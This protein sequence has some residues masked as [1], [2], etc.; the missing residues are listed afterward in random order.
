[1]ETRGFD[2]LHAA[3]FTESRTRGRRW[4]REVGNPGRDDKARAVTDLQFRESDGAEEL[5][6]RLADVEVSHHSPLVIPSEAEG[7][8]VGLARTQNSLES[9][10]GPVG[11]LSPVPT[12]SVLRI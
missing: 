7:S 8:A 6:I 4:Q 5:P 12:H 10:G 3:L 1:M 11:F 2:D 9:S